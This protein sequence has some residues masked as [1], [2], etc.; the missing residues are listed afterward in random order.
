MK[1]F[2]GITILMILFIMEGQSLKAQ[3]LKFGHINSD[4]LIL[5][6]PEFDSARIKLDRFRK[7]LINHLELMSSELNKKNEAYNKE[8]KNLSDVV[9]NVKE[10]EM[11]DMNR[12]I[13]EFQDMA[14]TQLQEKQLEFFQPV[15]AKV[16]KA[17]QDVGKENDYLYIFNSS[18]GGSLIYF[19][20]AIST[21]VTDM[22]KVKL[23][24]R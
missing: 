16:E 15:Y 10:Q 23:K 14:Q 5:E 8:S 12:R 11:M 4:E 20:K 21:D 18:Q 9:R 24:L 17:I 22:V 19:D 1:R 6:M 13:Q 7:E 3:K 2:I